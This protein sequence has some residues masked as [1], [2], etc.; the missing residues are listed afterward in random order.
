MEASMKDM[1]SLRPWSGPLIVEQRFRD[2]AEAGQLLASE[3]CDFA[4]RRDVV[5]LGLPRGGVPVASEIARALDVALDVLIVRKLGMPGHEELA[6]GAVAIGGIRVLNR[7]EIRFVS[8]EQIEEAT[9]R[10]R[11][12][13][14]RQEVL[15]RKGRPARRLS[16]QSVIIVDDGAATGSTMRAA[17]SAVRAQH[18]AW[19]VVALPIAPPETCASLAKSVDELICLIAPTLFFSVGQWYDDFSPCTDDEVCALLEGLEKPVEVGT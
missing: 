3:L 11:R 5:V 7:Q 13:V 9:R 19:L 17:I 15:Y 10:V 1:D 12:E 6:V 2:R 4:H 18:P 8:D 16:G 14:E